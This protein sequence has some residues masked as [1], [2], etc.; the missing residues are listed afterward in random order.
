MAACTELGAFKAT[1]EFIWSDCRDD[2]SLIHV[3]KWM[4]FVP[5]RDSVGSWEAIRTGE[6]SCA[7]ISAQVEGR[8]HVICVYTSDYR[9]VDDV[10]AVGSKVVKLL[11]LQNAIYYK[12]DIFTYSGRSGSIFELKAGR[13]SLRPDAGLL[14]AKD[15]TVIRR[16]MG[17]NS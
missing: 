1:D 10:G 4:I 6:F 11:A 15:L 9:K 5:C 2:K 8:A 17:S 16:K 12:P 14:P 3:G 13:F 7:K